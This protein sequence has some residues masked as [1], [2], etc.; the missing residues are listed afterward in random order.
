[1]SNKKHDTAPYALVYQI[2]PQTCGYCR[3]AIETPIYSISAYPEEVPL[4]G[5]TIVFQVYLCH[6]CEHS[7]GSVSSGSDEQIPRIWD[8]IRQEMQKSGPTSTAFGRVRLPSG[9]D[10][11]K[12]DSKAELKGLEPVNICILSYGDE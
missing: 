12:S 8:F 11:H 10:V 3:S 4:S 6:A 2:S 9:P 1:M 7:A 5:H